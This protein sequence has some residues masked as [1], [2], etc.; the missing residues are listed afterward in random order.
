VSSARWIPKIAKWA[1]AAAIVT[2]LAVA[3]TLAYRAWRASRT[4]RPVPAAVPSSVEQRSLKFTFSKVDGEQTVFTIR[5]GQATQFS[6]QKPSLLED[7]DIV[8]YGQH[9]ER[10]DEIHTHSCEYEPSTGAIVCHG[11]VQLDLA[12]A[13]V[14]GRPAQEAAA[15]IH[16]E[17]SGVGFNRDTGEATSDAPLEFR[18][19]QGQGIA[20]G[21]RYSSRQADITLQRDVQLTLAPQRPGGLPTNIIAQGGLTYDRRSGQVV[22]RGPVEISKGGRT[23]EAAALTLNVD[24]QMRPRQAIA[25]GRAKLRIAQGARK[26][27]FEADQVEIGFDSQGRAKEIDAGGNV[28][29]IQQAPGAMRLVAK[30][31]LVALDPLNQQPRTVDA[32]G[33]V[34]LSS[35]SGGSSE[36]LATSALH[37]T[38]VPVMMETRGNGRRGSKRRAEAKAEAVRLDRA[39]SGGPAT[40]VWQ[41]GKESLRLDAKQLTAEFGAD[42]RI[43]ELDGSAG[44]HLERHEP[45]RDPVVTDAEK[46]VAHFDA[47]EWSDAEESGNVR[48]AQG[49]RKASAESARWTRSK[50]ELELDGTAHVSDPTGQTLADNIVWNQQSGWLRAAG[51]V[52][53]TYFA[54]AKGETGVAPSAGPANI[55]ARTLVADPAAGEATYSGDARLWQGDLAIQADRIDLRRTSGELV[56]QGK[57]IGAFPQESHELG[58]T[59]RSGKASRSAPSGPVLWRVRANRLTYVNAGTVATKATANG[60]PGEAV[61]DGGVEA[62]STDGKIEA[63]KLVLTLQRDNSGRAELKQATASGGVKI[64]QGE[65]WGQGAKLIYVAE[66]GKFVLTGGNPSLHDTTGNLV[67]GDQLTFYVANDTILVESSKGSRTLTRHPIPN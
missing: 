7:V 41:S 39:T 37:L 30:Q 26:G 35:T 51:H 62:W 15:G 45:G 32:T 43:R 17:A 49:T 22:L 2:V 67:R 52:R 54:N 13:P 6:H 64:R 14:Q 66:P 61:L 19:P 4:A 34:R 8:V 18:F 1:A 57:V 5:A 36:R 58:K 11:K 12:S 31:L 42:S 63:E 9:G 55:V 21:V 40:V 10:H 28:V 59:S 53:S 50:N 48:A 46:L 24:E 47:G 25:G 20:T 16:I 56:A 33:D 44:V 23:L 38:A 3:A 27:G 65:R 29:A 60:V